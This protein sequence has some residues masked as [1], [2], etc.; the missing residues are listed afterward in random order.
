MTA[1]RT[2]TAP[3]H[4]IAPLEFTRSY[5][6][7]VVLAKPFNCIAIFGWGADNGKGRSWEDGG[8]TAQRNMTCLYCPLR[9]AKFTSIISTP[10]QFLPTSRRYGQVQGCLGSLHRT[11]STNFWTLS[12][13]KEIGLCPTSDTRVGVSVL[14]LCVGC[15]TPH[16]DCTSLVHR[17][18]L[19]LRAAA[20]VSV[21][22][23]CNSQG[24]DLLLQ[25]RRCGEFFSNMLYSEEDVLFLGGVLL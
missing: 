6:T 25:E 17:T 7:H 14:L 19:R 2:Y 23:V 5:G 20:E 8:L 15:I 22:R 1:K 16:S 11:A 9:A 4:H 3:P 13:S 24:L 12:T 18:A 10:R 21:L